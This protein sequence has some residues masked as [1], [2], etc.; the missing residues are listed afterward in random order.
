MIEFRNITYNYN[1]GD[2]AEYAALRSLSLKI[3]KGEFIGIAGHT[4]SGKSTAAQIAAGLINPTSGEILIDGKQF[5][6]AAET[7]R[8]LRKRVGIVFQYP[9]HQLFEE[10]VYRDI[11]FAPKNRGLGAEKADECV[12]RSA[13]LAGVSEELFEKSPFELSGGQKRRVAIAGVLAANPS[14]LILDEPA[15]G[16]DPAGRRKLLSLLRKIHAEASTSIILISHSMEDLAENAGRIVILGGGEKLADDIPENIFT[17]GEL[18][19]KS[20]LDMPE[21]TKTVQL[22][23]RGGM[24]LDSRIFT[25]SDAAKAIA[26]AA[27]VIKC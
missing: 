10:T 2:A 13:A 21:I 11:A 14:V 27:G 6:S 17:N 22:L 23:R 25:V 20:G 3:E 12:R 8:E 1:S 18:L 5:E 4:G 15:A 9:E 7:A 26:K 16:L 19:K 24:E